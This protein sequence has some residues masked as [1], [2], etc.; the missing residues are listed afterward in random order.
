MSCA[1]QA[2]CTGCRPPAPRPSDPSPS[3]VV[4]LRPPSS[5]TGTTQARSAA[6]SM[7][8]VQAPQTPMPQPN[9]VPV[10]PTTSRTAHSSGMSS[11]TSIV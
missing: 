9:L 2:D 3:I 7:C 4:T 5:P 10:S 8:T 11:G 1:I 6:P